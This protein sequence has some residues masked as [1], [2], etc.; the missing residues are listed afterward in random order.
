MV[1]GNPFVAPAKSAQAFAV[2]KVNVQANALFISCFSKCLLEASSPLFAGEIVRLPV[3]HGGV[4]GIA[5]SWYI[6]FGKKG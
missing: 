1:L 3:G 4:T 5:G 6:V 2:G